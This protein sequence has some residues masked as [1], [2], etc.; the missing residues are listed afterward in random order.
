MAAARLL[1]PQRGDIQLRK[2]S[3]QTVSCFRKKCVAPSL[4]SLCSTSWSSAGHVF[5]VFPGYL[6]WPGPTF[7]PCRHLEL[8]AKKSYT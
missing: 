6:I 4:H 2:D 7:S 5:E 3:F 1:Q 8:R